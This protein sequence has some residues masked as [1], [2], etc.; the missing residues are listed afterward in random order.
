MFFGAVMM[1]KA[2]ASYHL[3]P[4]Y[5]CPEL[6]RTISPELKKRMQGKSCFNFREPDPALFA[7]LGN[8]TKASLEKYREKKWL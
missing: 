8:L 5:V 6:V 2:Y 1:G 7:Q 4:L 3:M